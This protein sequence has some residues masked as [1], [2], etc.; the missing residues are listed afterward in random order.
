[1]GSIARIELDPTSGAVVSGGTRP[2]GD[3]VDPDID[4]L[5]AL[6]PLPSAGGRAESKRAP[7]D[8]HKRGPVPGTAPTL[9]PST[10]ATGF[11][12]SIGSPPAHIGTGGVADLFP[13][14]LNVIVHKA[15]ELYDA[16]HGAKQDPF[17][18]LSIRG[19]P[20]TL[21]TTADHAGG[22]EPKWAQEHFPFG[23]KDPN[24]QISIEA[25][26]QG[27]ITD[28]FLGGTILPVADI[29][30]RP[31]PEWYPLGRDAGGK[32]KP[33]GALL[34]SIQYLPLSASTTIVLPPGASGPISSPEPIPQPLPQQ[35]YYPPP[36]SG[37]NGYP[38][39]GQSMLGPIGGGYAPQ[40]G[41]PSAPSSS[42]PA[43]AA[44]A[45]TGFGSGGGFS[46]P[47]PLVMHG[48]AALSAP[49]GQLSSG[50]PSNA[51]VMGV[52][53][54]S[55]AR[56][57]YGGGGGGSGHDND[58]FGGDASY[59]AMTDDGIAA[60]HAGMRGVMGGG[61]GASSASQA[62][63]RRVAS[64]DR[65]SL[66]TVASNYFDEHEQEGGPPGRTP[67]AAPDI[68]SYSPDAGNGDDELPPAYPGSAGDRKGGAN[69]GG[70]GGAG[71][72]GRGGP[73][74]SGGVG[75]GI[76]GGRGASAAAG[77]GGGG[78]GGAGVGHRR[79]GSRQ[80]T[81]PSL[82]S[83]LDQPL[84]QPAGPRKLEEQPDMLYPMYVTLLCFLFLFLFLFFLF[85]YHHSSSLLMCNRRE[86]GEILKAKASADVGSRV[87][88]AKRTGS[89]PGSI[90][91][92]M[93][94]PIF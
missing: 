34:L 48:M 11:D 75:G 79:V 40:Q 29:I 26:N 65:S 78:Q 54:G 20:P 24:A 37:Y 61:M 51:P 23:V 85:L 27:A 16:K 87:A 64:P 47:T 81:D 93:R 68:P 50:G 35:Q 28:D 8:D 22:K 9:P 30:R 18:K 76:G 77:G 19:Q 45:G 38:P 7:Y 46:A 6:G 42:P 14:T 21:K 13:G 17:I 82:Q 3:G 88:A 63:P 39:P 90:S 72:G 80:A 66:S 73:S 49:Y 10:T 12:P 92:G 2:S 32:R 43:A 59:Q 31:G 5:E 94:M 67:K 1:L 84:L 52:S 56:S 4:E 58:D 86:F 70:G 36:N 62:N 15:R 53:S 69:A 89:R 55:V 41:Y 25:Y 71:I 57:G 33:A 83:R 60:S 44:A 91:A 74:A